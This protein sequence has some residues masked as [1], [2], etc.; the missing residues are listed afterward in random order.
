M[1]LLKWK[2]LFTDNDNL[3][4]CDKSFDGSWQK[5]VTCQRMVLYQVFEKTNE[6]VLDFVVFI[7]WES[8]KDTRVRAVLFL[9]FIRVF[10][11]GHWQLTEQQGKGGDH[12]LFHSTNSTCSRTC[13]YLFV[14]FYV[15]WLSHI[16][17]HNA[18]IYQTATQWDLPPYRITIWLIDWCCNVD[19]RLL[20]CWFDFR[21]CYNYFTWEPG[22]LELASTIILVLQANR[23]TKCASNITAQ[24]MKSRVARCNCHVMFKYL[25]GK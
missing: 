11:H 25:I 22:V 5:E 13:R 21:F 18:F 24:I 20:A 9:F 12:L 7:N 19:F 10:F 16:F 2:K 6:K 17:N 8:E 4:D 23:L 15:R 3:I 1:Q 14:I